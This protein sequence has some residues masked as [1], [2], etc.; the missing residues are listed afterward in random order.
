[1]RSSSTLFWRVA[2][3]S[4]IIPGDLKKINLNLPMRYASQRYYDNLVRVHPW[5]ASA[6]GLWGNY[7]NNAFNQYDKALQSYNR[8]LELDPE[9]GNAWF[10]KGVLYFEKALQYDPALGPSITRVEQ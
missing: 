10:S 5:N 9:Y 2:D 6:W 8:S 4:R 3:V 7:Y 1:M